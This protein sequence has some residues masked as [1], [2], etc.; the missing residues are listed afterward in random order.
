[1]ISMRFWAFMTRISSLLFLPRM[2][3]A[4]LQNQK[5][6]LI[7]SVNY[8]TSAIKQEKSC[9]IWEIRGRENRSGQVPQNYVLWHRILME[10]M[11][12]KTTRIIPSSLNTS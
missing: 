7:S 6:N 11:L 5:D 12:V 3:H 10:I 4:G 8:L 1:M 2:L 9:I